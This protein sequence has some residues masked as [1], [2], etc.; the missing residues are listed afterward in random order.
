M[1]KKRNKEA[2]KQISPFPAVSLN[3]GLQKSPLNIC[4]STVIPIAPCSPSPLR[5]AHQSLWNLIFSL[6]TDFTLSAVQQTG[7]GK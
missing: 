5:G 1:R 6:L 7:Q 2:C 3:D 4:V